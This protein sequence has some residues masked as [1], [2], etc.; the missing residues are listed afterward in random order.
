MSAERIRDTLKDN[1]WIMRTFLLGRPGVWTTQ[2]EITAAT[3]L[4]GTEVREICQN[5]PASFVS[6]TFGYKSVAN[7]SRGEVQH[8]VTVLISRSTKM[9]ERAAAL[10]G[11]LS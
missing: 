7:A 10:S 5:F 2:S 9:L 11:L 3:N 1:F 6:S 4:R 8:N